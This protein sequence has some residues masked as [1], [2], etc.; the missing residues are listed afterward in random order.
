MYLGSLVWGFLSPLVKALLVLWTLNPHS[1]FHESQCVFFLWHLYVWRL[2][3]SECLNDIFI[4][5]VEA[6]LSPVC[7]DEM[8]NEN[9]HLP[10]YL[11]AESTWDQHWWPKSLWNPLKSY[12]WLRL[13]HFFRR[14]RFLG[15]LVAQKGQR[16]VRCWGRDVN[17]L[18]WNAIGKTMTIQC[19]YS[20]KKMSLDV[21]R[22][23]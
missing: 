9:Q 21:F 3:P 7:Y 12:P 19:F 10:A 16:D 4:F 6:C 22:C 5:V 13:L 17:C 23:V 1:W 20:F 2:N 15:D 11:R 18:V 8:P 14:C